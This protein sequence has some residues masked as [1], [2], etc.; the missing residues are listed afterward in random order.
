[1]RN[2]HCYLC[3]GLCVQRRTTK[4]MQC[5]IIVSS[6]TLTGTLPDADKRRDASPSLGT[7]PYLTNLCKY[8]SCIQGPTSSSEEQHQ[9][10]SVGQS[11]LLAHR[12]QHHY[13]AHQLPTWPIVLPD[14]GCKAGCSPRLGS[15]NV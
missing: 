3:K 6:S 12:T 9:P 2:S 8:C 13:S 14:M 7:N 10:T 1:M 11:Q 5:H 4:Y 15:G